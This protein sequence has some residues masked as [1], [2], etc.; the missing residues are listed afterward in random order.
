MGNDYVTKILDT[1]KSELLVNGLNLKNGKN[2]TILIEGDVDSVE[3]E[4]NNDSYSMIENYSD[5]N[6]THQFTCSFWMK[7]DD[8]SKGFGH[9][10]FGNLNDKG[11]ALLD[12]EKITP[13]ITIQSNKDVYVYNT[14]FTLLDKASLSNEESTRINS[15]RIKDIYRS[16]HLNTYYTINID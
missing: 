12:D 1:I 16:E 9:Q 10:I 2:A 15:S 14:D 13:L 7:S 4:L 8:W 6:D 3:Y 5:I 11:F